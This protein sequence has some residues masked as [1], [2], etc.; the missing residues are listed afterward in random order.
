M[1]RWIAMG[2][3]VVQRVRRGGRLGRMGSLRGARGG[4]LRRRIPRPGWCFLLVRRRVRRVRMVGMRC[5]R[6]RREV[7]R[8]SLGILVC[9]FAHYSATWIEATLTHSVSLSSYLG[10]AFG[11][12][13]SRIISP[14][15]LPVHDTFAMHAVSGSMAYC[16]R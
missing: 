3:G 16:T 7:G 8:D 14:S 6:V 15:L 9:T 2:G 12:Y 13:I 11:R 10:P 5:L 1:R 4:R